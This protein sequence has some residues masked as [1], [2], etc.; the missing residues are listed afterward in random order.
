[1]RIAFITLSILPFAPNDLL[2]YRAAEE[3][4]LKGHQVLIAPLDWGGDNAVE[5][6]LIARQGALILW[7]PRHERSR[8]LAV[9][10]WQKLKHQITDYEKHWAPVG[11]FL[12][13]LIVVNGPGTFYWCTVPGLAGY[14][15][16]R[17]I[18]FVTISQ[19][20]D[21]NTSL[22]S[23]TYLRARPL[24]ENSGRC[25][26]VSERNLEVARGQLCL[27]LPQALVFDNPPNLSDW[28][29]IPFPRGGVRMAMVARLECAI[30][31][32]A[33]VLRALTEEQWKTRDWELDLFGGG[34]DEA[35]LRDLIVFLG[36]Q[37]RVRLRGHVSDVRRIWE[38]HQVLVM[39]SSLEG[40]PLALTEAM[41]CGRPA[42][43]TDVGG[44]AELIDH[45]ETG[46]IA[47]SPT[48]TSLGRALNRAWLQQGRWEEMGRR[49]HDVMLRRLQP[50]PGQRLAELL[51]RMHDEALGQC[52][53]A[54][55]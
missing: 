28:D 51:T 44:N 24:F 32:Q 23:D 40:K 30:K 49:A 25:I 22:S 38:E 6:E 48:V 55:L 42:V 12:P 45:G 20:N 26:F 35:Y 29:R 11:R 36:L 18:P 21:E 14:L 43:V 9:R 8:Y 50:T 27:H 7:R 39:G 15:M 13:D 33:L 31:G 1:M 4:L 34:P 5:Y 10:Q 46:F 2:W 3:L 16:G 54:R 17:R 52:P 47:E 37:E 19:G 41:L 53:R